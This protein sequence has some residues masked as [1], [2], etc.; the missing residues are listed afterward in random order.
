MRT[1]AV[2]AG[3]PGRHA[4]YARLVAD[5]INMYARRERGALSC[6]DLSDAVRWEGLAKPGRC[7]FTLWD[8]VD[9]SIDRIMWV[10]ADIYV[11]RPILERELPDHPFSAV[12]EWRTNRRGLS[13]A[14]QAVFG[15]YPR[16]FNS[17]VFAATR[18][19]IAAFD[20]AREVADTIFVGKHWKSMD[21]DALNYGVWKT[22]GDTTEDGAGWC[23]LDPKFNVMY[24][25]SEDFCGERKEGVLYHFWG[26]RKSVYPTLED[27]YA[28]TADR[29]E[30]LKG[31]A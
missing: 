19:A 4:E 26:I 22:L 29:S 6:I 30:A 8:L 1:L 10:D 18:E 12:E 20:L 11:A 9:R 17:G 25:Q 14:Y 15:G 24:Q 3:T 27:V 5:R 13:Q 21:Q 23:R 7:K 2:T 16:A 28:D 31:D